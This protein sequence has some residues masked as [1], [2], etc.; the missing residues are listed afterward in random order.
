VGID[1]GAV[2]E[3]VLEICMKVD[4]KAGVELGVKLNVELGVEALSFG[5]FEAGTSLIWILLSSILL[6]TKSFVDLVNCSNFARRSAIRLLRRNEFTSAA[7]DGA[8]CKL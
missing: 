6:V 2:S 3:F 7:S 4:V 8:Y 5:L 1:V